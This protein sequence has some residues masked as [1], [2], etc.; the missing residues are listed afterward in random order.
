LATVGLPEL[1]PDLKW[2]DDV[3][4]HVMGGYAQLQVL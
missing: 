3:N 1:T 2:R 4:F